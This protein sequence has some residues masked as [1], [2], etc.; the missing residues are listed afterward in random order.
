MAFWAW[1]RIITLSNQPTDPSCITWMAF[2]HYNQPTILRSSRSTDLGWISKYKLCVSLMVN[3]LCSTWGIKLTFY[4]PPLNSSSSQFSDS[5]SRKVPSG[6]GHLDQLW[7]TSPKHFLASVLDFHQFRKLTR[8][9]WTSLLDR[10][11]RKVGTLVYVL[12]KQALLTNFYTF[13]SYLMLR[14]RLLVLCWIKSH[15]NAHFCLVPDFRG[16]GLSF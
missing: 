4:A 5:Q 7:Q 16:K 10:H 12:P 13:F 9:I 15:E 6:L 14:L 11:K 2:M 3:I 1:C 8:W